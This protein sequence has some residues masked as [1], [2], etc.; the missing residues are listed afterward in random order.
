MIAELF[1]AIVVVVAAI[2]ASVAALFGNRRDGAAHGGAP[3]APGANLTPA[4]CAGPVACA[5]GLVDFLG[6]CFT[7]AEADAARAVVDGNSRDSFPG[8]VL[9]DARLPY[10]AGAFH[11]TCR[12][13][14]LDLPLRASALRHADWVAAVRRT[15]PDV[16]VVV[17]RVAYYEPNMRLVYAAWFPDVSFI[18]ALDPRLDPADAADAVE[19]VTRADPN[20]TARIIARGDAPPTP[21]GEPFAY[22]AGH[23]FGGGARAIADRDAMFGAGRAEIV[24]EIMA[25]RPT[26][27]AAVAPTTY[28]E[29]A[30]GSSPEFFAGDLRMYPWGPCSGGSA[31]VWGPLGAYAPAGPVGRT[32]SADEPYSPPVAHLDAAGLEQ[33][34]MRRNLAER[35]F[36]WYPA[37]VPLDARGGETGICCCFDCAG[38][39]SVWRAVFAAGGRTP[40]DSIVHGGARARGRRA[41]GQ[42]S[43]RSRPSVRAP[44]GYDAA[45]G[46]RCRAAAAELTRRL[47]AGGH[48]AALTALPHGFRQDVPMAVKRTEVTELVRAMNSEISSACRAAGFVEFN[49]HCL[50]AAERTAALLESVERSPAPELTLGPDAPGLPYRRYNVVAAATVRTPLHVGQRKL[51]MEEVDFLTAHAAGARI[52]VYAGAAPG[53]HI[54]YL[55]ALFPWLEWE[56]FDPREFSSVTRRARRVRA[57]V[58]FFGDEDAA[59]FAGQPGVLFISDVRT[60]EAVHTL[61]TAAAN[62]LVERDMAM[63]RRWVEL[64]RPAAFSL[65]FRLPYSDGGSGS[66]PMP[67]EYLAGELRLQPW[68]PLSSTETRLVGGAG[69]WARKA[70]YDPV[71]YEAAN[72]YINAIVRQWRT[73]PHGVSSA[74][75]PGLDMCFDCAAEVLLWRTYE[76]SR[77][78]P[79]AGPSADAAVAKHM[80]NVA[81][82]IRRGLRESYH[83]L[84]P[85][86]PLVDKMSWL[87]VAQRTG[88]RFLG[89]E[90][91]PAASGQAR[92]RARLARMAPEARAALGR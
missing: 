23:M 62:A 31:I 71:K 63:Q 89:P 24:A 11:A 41:R 33:R 27:F 50:T 32:D 15:R 53:T 35:T 77:G 10:R 52:V 36:G 90:W 16:R 14:C 61:D 51:L 13:P 40:G 44:V 55:A 54:P 7:P 86:M 59:R 2:I 48:R 72:Y 88:A 8:L 78:R 92:T 67:V 83:G 79:A 74:A 91:R 12:R 22:F 47:T 45:I 20:V 73:F 70:T 39:I 80:L 9:G 34:I 46:H 65:K 26:M 68:A 29:A 69:D 28:S 38:E 87:A 1:G 84:F 66:P 6:D 18:A 21:D 4:G 60:G 81:A 57:H 17:I 30:A 19:C 58:Q 64:M 76:S 43:R 25:W 82:L 85:D 3:G 49:T 75:V 37:D 42:S 5:D 56:L